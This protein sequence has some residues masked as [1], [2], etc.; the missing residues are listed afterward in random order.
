MHNKKMLDLENEGQGRTV[1]HLW[2]CHFMANIN[3]CIS[4]MTYFCDSSFCV[5]DINISNL[6]PWKLRSR[7][8]H[9]QW[10]IRWQISTSRKVILE[11]FSLALT[12]FS[13][14][15]SH[16]KIHDL[17]NVGQGHDV[18]HSQWSHSMANIN[19]YNIKVILEHFLLALI[20]LQ[21]F[22]FQNVWPWKCM[23]RKWCTTFAMAP[24]NS[25]YLTS[26][27]I[28]IVMFFQSLFINPLTAK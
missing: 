25:K 14:K 8:Q 18:Q 27:L 23:S 19:L 6:W 13:R 20:V 16:F 10:P 3:L 26:Y 4:H 21:I 11:Q 12:I 28:A 5:R 7:V 2:W 22:I 1:Q 9:S 15:N 17:E 24:F